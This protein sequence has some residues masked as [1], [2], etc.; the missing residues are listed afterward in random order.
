M[1]KS[2][3]AYGRASENS[4][5]KAI[6]AE[7]KSVNNRYFDCNIKIPRAYGFLEEKIKSFILSKGI[8]RGKLDVYISIDITESE[9]AEITLDEAYAESYL[10]ALKQ[11]R[12]KFGLT[13]DISVMS[14]ASNREL[15]HVK[16]PEEDHDK[17]WDELRPVLECAMNEFEAMRC[18]EGGN[19]LADI[20]EKK[21]H[22]AEISEKISAI[23]EN[24]ISAYRERLEARLRQTLENMGI[25]P[26]EQRILTECAIFADKIC[27]DEETVRLKSHLSAFDE[28]LAEDAPVGR[29]LD[30]LIQEINREINTSGSKSNDSEIARLVVDAKCELEKIR[31]QIQNIE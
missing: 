25:E 16:V 29:K 21:K 9:G 13:D 20:T 8:S 2:M 11:L 26:D 1:I 22:I 24:N 3:T 6:V 14:V 7:L 23:S 17:D 18:R 4:G 27:I 15:F 10:K 28:I 5:G 30:F 19:L 31:E 12:D